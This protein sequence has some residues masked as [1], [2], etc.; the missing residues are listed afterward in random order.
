MGNALDRVRMAQEVNDALA[1][2]RTRFPGHTFVLCR[3]A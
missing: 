1:L 2:Y 3:L